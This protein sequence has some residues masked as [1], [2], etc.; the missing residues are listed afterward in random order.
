MMNSYAIAHLVHLYGAIAF[1]GGVIFEALILS[2]LHSSRVSCESRR[3]V[4]QAISRRA[5]R[6]MPWIVGAVFLS[7]GAMVHRY[8]DVLKQ[9]FA[10]SFGTQL[11]F[12]ILLSL[13]ILLHFIIAVCK[14]K[15][16]TLTVAWSKYIHSAVLIQMLLI[17]FLAKSMFY[18]QF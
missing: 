16:G 2:A 3:E 14:M 6:V 5:V 15:R 10:S 18:F 17:V 12:K 4:E 9:P 7:G 11:L 1:V 8:L 13:G